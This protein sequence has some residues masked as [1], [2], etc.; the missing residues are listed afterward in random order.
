[1]V[2]VSSKNSKNWN[3]LHFAIRQNNAYAI[4]LMLEGE[5][6]KESELKSFSET[7]VKHS[8]HNPWV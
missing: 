3:A 1:M 5:A 6:R 4:S 8:N 2:K 7:E